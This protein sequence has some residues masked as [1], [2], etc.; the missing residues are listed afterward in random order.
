MVW[1]GF[2]KVTGMPS[3]EAAMFDIIFNS[4]VA[5]IA[6]L[7]LLG[8]RIGNRSRL[9]TFLL[10]V[11]IMAI[12]CAF[13][14]VSLGEFKLS[15]DLAGIS[16]VF[17]VAAATVLL[18]FVLA[19]WACRKSY[20]AIRFMLWLAVWIGAVCLLT[21]VIVA[22]ISVIVG[23]IMGN[24]PPLGFLLSMAYMIPFI[25]LIIAGFIYAILLPYMILAFNSDLFR[26]RFYGCFR[27][28]GMLAP[29]VAETE[30]DP[31]REQMT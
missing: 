13:G 17:A 12:M 10:A 4:F 5:G 31:T 11:L 29:A 22:V 26:Q 3:S 23:A 28:K 24:A 6:A 14:I 7:W 1:L 30:I 27:L 15:S 16:M 9:A 20:S 25:S 19:G 8:N 21:M 2:K 18:A